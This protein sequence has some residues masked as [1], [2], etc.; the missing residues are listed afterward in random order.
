MGNKINIQI[1][2]PAKNVFL[3][4]SVDENINIQQALEIEDMYNKFPEIQ[5]LDI[6]IFSK[7]KTLDT[8]LNNLD[9]IEIYSPLI[10]DPKQQREKRVAKKR[11]ESDIEKSKWNLSSKHLVK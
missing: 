1:S 7:I 4:L 10:A 3:N 5:N 9:R 11:I 8:Q 2:Y 6:G